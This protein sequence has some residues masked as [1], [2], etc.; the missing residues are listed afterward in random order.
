VAGYN[1]INEPADPHQTRLQHFYARIEKAIRV[2]DPEHILFLD[3]NTYAMDFSA[4]NEVLPNCVYSIHDYA[5]M[6][7]PAGE[8]YKGTP[9]QNNVLQKSYERKIQFMRKYDVPVGAIPFFPLLVLPHI[10]IAYVVQ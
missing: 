3:G 2:V 1:P 10:Y 9:E 4:F 8:A 6:G 7:F 5:S